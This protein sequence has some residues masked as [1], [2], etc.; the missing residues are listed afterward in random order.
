M[1]AV[2][3]VKI[4][5]F[6]RSLITGS[7]L[8]LNSRSLPSHKHMPYIG[9]HETCALQC[10]EING[11]LGLQ[12]K[13]FQAPEEF[14]EAWPAAICTAALHPVSALINTQQGLK[15]SAT[16]KPSV[17]NQKVKKNSDNKVFTNLG[18]NIYIPH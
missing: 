4:T 9:I 14:L 3:A 12:Y 17:M 13:H 15:N 8:V 2:V 16:G 1:L 18:V 5:S 11:K 10:P 7:I 6:L